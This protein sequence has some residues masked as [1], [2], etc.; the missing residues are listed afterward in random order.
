MKRRV[1]QIYGFADV[2]VF[3]I[4][5]ANYCNRFWMVKKRFL[6][7]AQQNLFLLISTS[8]SK[9]LS[10][11]DQWKKRRTILKK[12]GN[13]IIVAD[14]MEPCYSIHLTIQYQTTAVRSNSDVFKVSNAK[15]AKTE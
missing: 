3:R 5:F 2:V 4:F 12:N 15:V 1:K 9:N 6:H 11:K 14:S 10:R 13:G 7:I 8:T